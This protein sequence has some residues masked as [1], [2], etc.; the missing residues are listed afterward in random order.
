MHLKHI[1]KVGEHVRV[2]FM[3]IVSGGSYHYVVEGKIQSI[4][5]H[6][7]LDGHQGDVRQRTTVEIEE[8]DSD[9]MLSCSKLHTG[10]SSYELYVA[11]NHIFVDQII[12][13][14]F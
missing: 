12:S 8:L 3:K 5:M 14:T 6:T 13:I 10:Q 4:K 1:F 2:T 11:G 7:Y 9:E